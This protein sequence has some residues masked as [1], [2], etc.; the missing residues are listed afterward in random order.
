[1]RLS[2]AR[3][4]QMPVHTVQQGE[5]LSRIALNYG[6]R[7]WKA[8]YN[9]AKNADFKKKRPDPNLIYP[10]DQIYIPDKTAKKIAV[11]TTKVHKFR[12]ALPQRKIK[13]AVEDWKHQRLVN[14]DYELEVEGRPYKGKTDGSGILEKSVPIGAEYG[15]L[16][17]NGATLKLA[18]AHLNPIDDTDDLGVTGIQMRLKNLGYDTGPI[19]GIQGPITTAAI[20]AFQADNP[21]LAVD[22]IC[23]PKTTAK[24]IERH[25][26]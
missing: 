10:G 7:D 23:G 21:P 16:K 4:V 13:I 18:I 17:I 26:C 19:D 1:M 2:G 15:K 20:K 22:G 24:L 6:F 3:S 9:H 25:G 12:V 14:M 5:C 8:I 11:E